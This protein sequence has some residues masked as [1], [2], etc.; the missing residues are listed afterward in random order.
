[1]DQGGWL[2]RFKRKQ[3]LASACGYS[4]S[5]PI[6]DIVVYQQGPL[7]LIEGETAK[8]NLAQP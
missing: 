5:N 4:E 3:P 2:T 7:F 8:N 1:M 6:H